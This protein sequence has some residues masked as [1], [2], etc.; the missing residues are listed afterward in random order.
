[1]RLLLLPHRHSRIRV[2]Q[3]LKRSYIDGS[4]DGPQHA[5]EVINNLGLGSIRD[6]HGIAT[7]VLE[8]HI[9]G[10]YKFERQK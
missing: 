5:I 6:D 8:G 10:D 7:H 3:I 4:T 1:M 9:S 2:R